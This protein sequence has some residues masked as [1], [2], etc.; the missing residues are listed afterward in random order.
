MAVEHLIN[1]MMNN[2]QQQMAAQIAAPLND[3]QLCA[4]MACFIDGPTTRSR[5][6]AAADMLAE[7]F[8]AL[9]PREQ[10]QSV[11]T[12]RNPLPLIALVQGK[13]MAREAE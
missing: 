12:L 2:Q 10:L 11:R 7:A 9:A 5:V 13:L 8:V 4:I 6:E 3:I 1:Q